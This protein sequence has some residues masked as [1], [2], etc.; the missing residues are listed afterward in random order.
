MIRTKLF[1]SHAST[2]RGWLDRIRTQL[3]PLERRGAIEAWDDTRILP[4][5][6]SQQELARAR[7]ATRVA[8]LIVSADFLA[9]PYV[10]EHELAP[11]LAA[12]DRGDVTVLPVIVGHCLFDLEPELSKYR[13]VN[14]HDAPLDAL[15]PSEQDKVLAALARV[16]LAALSPSQSAVKN[17]AAAGPAAAPATVAPAPVGVP[18]SV[19]ISYGRPDA[20]FARRLREALNRAGVKTYF[21]ETDAMPG[22]RIHREVYRALNAHDRVLLVCSQASLA[23]SGVRNEIEET[24]VREAKDGGATYLLPITLD[25]FV[26][27]GW[28]ATNPDLADR[29]LLR[30]IADFRGADKDDEKFRAAL[31]RIVQT[32]RFIVI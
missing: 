14:P 11:L 4:G 17:T 26:F 2:D 15:S 9:S 29:V 20:A 16:A 24:L 10:A 7:D 12:A 3:A 8:I 32:L 21:F 6:A 22:E 18:S 31:A 28:R 27:G 5:A 30:V 25:D 19:F 1:I 13:P 23:R